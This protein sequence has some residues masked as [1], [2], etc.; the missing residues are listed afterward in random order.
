MQTQ[1]A[2]Q[3]DPAIFYPGGTLDVLKVRTKA[4]ICVVGESGCGKSHLVRQLTHDPD[5]GPN[6][7]WVA[8]SEDA[9][10]TYGHPLPR[11][12]PFDSFVNLRAAA[13]ELIF[14]AEQGK[15]LPKVGV[16]DNMSSLCDYEMMRYKHEQPF[17]GK[18]GG[19][20][21][22]A[23]YKDLGEQGIETLL[24]LL[25]KVPMDFI[26]MVTAWRPGPGQPPLL[27]LPGKMLPAN[28]TRLTSSTFYMQS[29]LFPVQDEAKI[30]EI[31]A[32]LAKYEQPHRTFEFDG[33][34]FTGRIINRYFT[35]MNTGEVV[36]KGHHSLS[37]K[38][39]AV[40]PD[41]LRKIHGQS[42]TTGAV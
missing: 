25:S 15:R 22:L 9:T 24:T 23:E 18:T 20:D 11:I 38:E 42:P 33:G 30:A 3:V 32:N 12:A 37:L 19:R 8:M 2:K 7:V 41:V 13:D 21:Q 16:L 27:C 1:I 39:P 28:L 26:V 5:Y 17:R 36:A 29:E 6:E 40:L 35:T 14:M 34:K 31:A 10:A 4:M